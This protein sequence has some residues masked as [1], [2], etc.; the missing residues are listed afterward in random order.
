M[1]N[2]T[3]KNE[4]IE[5]MAVASC[6]ARFGPEATCLFDPVP[7]GFEK[8]SEAQKMFTDRTDRARKEATAQIA[9]LT[10]AGFV[11]VPREPTE[12]M[13]RAWEATNW[14]ESV[15]DD[16]FTLIQAWEDSD[17]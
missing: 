5:V 2:D 16:W 15:T 3:S 6:V 13:R 7:N 4:V 12:E 8:S 1:K 17:G 10:A 14:P 11:I 9:A